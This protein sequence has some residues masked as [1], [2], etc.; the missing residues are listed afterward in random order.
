MLVARV[1]APGSFAIL[2]EKAALTE[3]GQ[4]VAEQ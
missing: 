4:A 3:A 2:F 1:L